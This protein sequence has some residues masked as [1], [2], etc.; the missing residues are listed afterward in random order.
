MPSS[1]ILRDNST[2][3][4][5]CAKVAAG[6]GSAKSSAGTYTAWIEV[7]EPV[8]V[9][10]MRSCSMPISSASVG[11]GLSADAGGRDGHAARAHHL[12]QDRLHHLDPG[13]VRARRR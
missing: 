2:V 10:V 9:E 4:S 11:G 6:D 12:H 1:A 13:R 8:L 7:M 5:K 3:A